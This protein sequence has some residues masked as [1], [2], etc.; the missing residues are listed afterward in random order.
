MGTRA[1]SGSRERDP[2]ASEVPDALEK[3]VQAGQV[4]NR[5][6]RCIIRRRDV[7]RNKVVKRVSHVR[8][9]LLL[10]NACPYRKPTQVDEERILRPAEE[11][12]SRNSAK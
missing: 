2:G 6:I 10:C 4:Y 8:E 3:P 5:Q 12:L 1:E 7:E 9:K 11:A